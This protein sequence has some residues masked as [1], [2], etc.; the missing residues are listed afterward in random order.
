M[1]RFPMI[2]CGAL[3]L[4]IAAPAAKGDQVEAQASEQP[5]STDPVGRWRVYSGEASQRFGVPL[6]WIERVMRAESGGQ[7]R[8]N[9]RPITSHA[10]AMGLMQIMP[11]TWA[12][13]RARLG[14]GPD[15]HDP[16][17]NILA[18]TFYLRMMYDRFGYPGLFGAYHA[19]PARYAEWV[20]SGRALPAE[21][22]AYLAK[23]SNRPG[24]SIA[25][26]SPVPPA[27]L[28]AI[29]R[30]DPDHEARPPSAAEG[31]FVPLSTQ[32]PASSEQP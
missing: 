19:G 20:T 28:F 14:L 32:A 16:R 31:L 15:P 8:L 1:S 26:G 3:V 17:D 11:A 2:V 6:D 12:E 4:L 10:G 5:V 9:G 13:L 21:T 27:S 7:T 22:R 18:G 30:A 25:S 23:L 24:P 29:R